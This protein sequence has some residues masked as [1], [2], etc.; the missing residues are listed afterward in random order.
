M[1][2][3]KL[4]LVEGVPCSGKS[5]TAETILNDITASGIKGHCYLEW[6]ENNPITI[7]KMEDLATIIATTKARKERVLQQWQ[8]FTTSATIHAAVNIIESRFWQ[9]DAM[10]L[11]LS[12][13]S[14]KEI[15][16][17][18]RRVISLIAA[19]DP[20]LVYLA[21]KD[22]EQ[23]HTEIAKQRNE[24][25]RASGREGSWEE[26]GNNVYVQQRWF[27]DRSLNSQAMTQFF[28]EWA[29]IADRLFDRFPYRKLRIPDPQIDWEDTYGSIRAFL[30]VNIQ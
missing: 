15:L 10:Y 30:D 12:G 21:P 6:E 23:L 9:T 3:T 29:V 24:K 20:V 1:I 2:E 18:N 7:G 19:L 4:I 5:T 16:E 11:Y 13:H 8:Q 14:E 22:I 27:T 26:W 17:S 28:N 25:W